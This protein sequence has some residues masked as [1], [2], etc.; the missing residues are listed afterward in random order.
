MHLLFVNPPN[1]PFTEKSLLIEPVDIVGL[2]SYME[3][4]GHTITLVDMDVKQLKSDQLEKSI[5]ALN[6]DC[7]I[8][9]FDYHIPLHT[10]ECLPEIQAIAKAFKRKGKKVIVGGKYATYHPE[11]FLFEGSP[12]DITV[13]HEMEMGLQSILSKPNW[14]NISLKNT[15]GIAFWDGKKIVQTPRNTMK[16]DLNLSPVTNRK[17]LELEDYID[18]RTILSSR[19]CF[20]KCDFCHVPGFWGQWR[21]QSAEKVVD[22]IENLALN[23]GAYKILFLD[24]NATA[25][26]KRMRDISKS[27]L[28]RNLKVRLGCLG[29][30]ASFEAS[31]MKLMFEAGFR[32]IHYGIESGDDSMLKAIHKRTNHEKIKDVIHQTKKMGF[33]VRTS[34]ILDLPHTTA[35]TLQNTYNLMMSLESDEIR[36]HYLALR[37]GSH[38]Y[39]KYGEKQLTQQYIH[40]G[41]PNVFL[42]QEDVD[43]NAFENK[44][45]EQLQ[46]K[47]YTL[48]RN[49]KDFS[50]LDELKKKNPKMKIVSTCPLRYGINWE[51][52]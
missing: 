19:G 51:N 25:N 46:S 9:I 4:I 30:I 50:N 49:A 33:R 14:N 45:I 36:I 20:M 17:I 24:D 52:Q 27:I 37:M 5:D 22:E 11:F 23:Y 6:P 29:T 3:S 47:N 48:V 21:A 31:T 28:K 34:W 35:E 42:T 8:I 16:F 40:K 7:G 1:S 26:P 13:S 12:V 39:E 41:R 15:K 2:A 18:V 38:Y 43:L 10:S 44:L 32:W